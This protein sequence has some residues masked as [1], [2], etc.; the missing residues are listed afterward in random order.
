MS[1]ASSAVNGIHLH[2]LNVAYDMANDPTVI[3]MVVRARKKL[4]VSIPNIARLIL[5]IVVFEYW[6]IQ[7]RQQ[8]QARSQVHSTNAIEWCNF[9]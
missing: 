9:L 2:Y 8:G 6:D 3:K 5:G 7:L 4:Y 1:R